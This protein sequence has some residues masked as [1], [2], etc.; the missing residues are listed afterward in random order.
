M[1]KICSANQW[2]C[3]FGKKQRRGKGKSRCGGAGVW[4]WCAAIHPRELWLGSRTRTRRFTVAVKILVNDVVLIADDLPLPS[5]LIVVADGGGSP[6]ASCTPIEAVSFEA[7]AAAV[8][9]ASSDAG[10]MGQVGS[11]TTRHGELLSLLQ[12]NVLDRQR[13]DTREDLRIAIVTW[14]GGPTTAAAGKPAWVA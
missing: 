4:I 11:A 10:S 9:V 1:W 12:R 8:A 5:S 14:I 2:W 6:A 3:V 13:W 7:G